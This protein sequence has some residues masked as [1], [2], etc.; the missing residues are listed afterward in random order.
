MYMKP[1]RRKKIRT[2]LTLALV[3][4]G[5]AIAVILI[6]A[7]S[8]L[9]PQ[10]SLLS[11]SVHALDVSLP[12][13]VVANEHGL[14]YN[15][16]DTLYL[17]DTSTGAEIWRQELELQEA[18]TVASSDFICNYAGKSLQLMDYNKNQ[19]FSTAID[20]EI[21]GAAVGNSTVAV[22]T[23]SV[24]EQNEKIYLATLFNANGKGEQLGQASFSTREVIDFGFYGDT[25]MF[26]SLTLDVSGIVPVSH[27]TTYKQDGSMTYNIQINSQVVEDVFITDNAFF[28]SGTS[29]LTSYSYFNTKQAEQQIYGWKNAAGSVT[30]QAVK[31]AYIPRST[32]SDIDAVKVYNTD[33][34]SL[35]I[36]LPRGVISLAVTQ[37]RLYAFTADIVYVYTMEGALEKQVALESPINR[38]QQVSDTCAVLWDQQKSYLMDL[39]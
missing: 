18:T 34:E 11:G 28:T 21:L 25:D 12:D 1:S 27:V 33:L 17:R 6:L 4:A 10:V 39:T 2:R 38:A 32:V 30:S 23:S 31:L 36:R 24:N 16:A 3:C 19:I 37:N 9:L 15:Q 20:S 26:W 35:H 5:I 14:L 7:F 22:L 8:G 29:A 13:N